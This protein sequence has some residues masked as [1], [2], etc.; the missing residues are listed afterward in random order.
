MPIGNHGKMTEYNIIII[1]ITMLV[2]NWFHHVAI[3]HAGRF[4]HRNI[5]VWSCVFLHRDLLAFVL[6]SKL[7]T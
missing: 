5:C 3:L 1:H 7:N 2:A 6:F 4:Q